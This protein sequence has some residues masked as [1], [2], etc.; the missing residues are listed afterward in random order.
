VKGDRAP[1]RSHSQVDLFR[2]S[3]LSL[4]HELTVSPDLLFAYIIVLRPVV[5]PNTSGDVSSTPLSE[6][7]PEMG[8]KNFEVT[9][10]YRTGGGTTL[11]KASTAGIHN[12]KYTRPSNIASPLAP[13]FPSTESTVDLAHVLS[14]GLAV[15]IDNGVVKSVGGIQFESRS[16]WPV[17]RADNSAQRMYSKAQTLGLFCWSEDSECKYQ[18]VCKECEGKGGANERRGPKNGSA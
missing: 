14:G 18:H 11:R 10:G 16:A 5:P 17:E 12:A 9:E 15:S 1:L 6:P 13:R 7:A 3:L 8:K 4:S 2:L